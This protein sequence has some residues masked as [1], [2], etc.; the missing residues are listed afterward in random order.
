MEGTEIVL[1][2]VEEVKIALANR[3]NVYQFIRSY[4]CLPTPPRSNTLI[5]FRNADAFKPV[6]IYSPHAE[7]I[8]LG[9]PAH[10]I[11]KWPVNLPSNGPAIWG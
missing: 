3:Y 9:R 6:L 7:T 4:S 5:K 8:S 11:S 2:K 10:P 1:K